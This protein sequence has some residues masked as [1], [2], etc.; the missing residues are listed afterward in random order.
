[1]SE[2][3]KQ[4]NPSSMVEIKYKKISFRDLEFDQGDTFFARGQFGDVKKAKWNGKVVAVKVFSAADRKCGFSPE[5]VSLSLLQ[6]HDH[7]VTLYG[8]CPTDSVTKRPFLVLEFAPLSLEKILHE[9]KKKY[10]YTADHVMSWSYQMALGLEF[11]HG[12]KMLHRDIKPSNI[13]LFHHGRVLK[14]CDFGT[15]KKLENTLSNTNAVGT[16]R[17]MAP[18]VIRGKYYTD[19]CD[20]FSYGIVLWEMLTRRRPVLANSEKSNN[21]MVIMFAMA[22]G[23]I[24]TKIPNLPKPMAQLIDKCFDGEPQNRPSVVEIRKKIGF[25]CKYMKTATPLIPRRQAKSESTHLTSLSDQSDQFVA[26]K[27]GT[28]QHTPRISADSAVEEEVPIEVESKQNVPAPVETTGYQPH[29][30]VSHGNTEQ[31]VEGRDRSKTVPERPTNIPP[32][33]TNILGPTGYTSPPSGT[34]TLGRYPGYT[35]QSSVPPTSSPSSQ[36]R[37]QPTPPGYNTIGHFRG[38][39]GRYGHQES[40]HEV[41]YVSEELLSDKGILDGQSE[42]Y[43]IIEEVMK[44]H[45]NFPV[46]SGSSQYVIAGLEPELQPIIPNENNP[47]SM[48]L[49]RQYSAISEQVMRIRKDYENLME[50][51]VK[52]NREMES[53]RKKVV[54]QAELHLEYEKQCKLKDQLIKEYDRLDR[55]YQGLMTKNSALPST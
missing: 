21:F 11:I 48:E 52:L 25:L 29:A 54:Q 43:Q 5:L 38:Q 15:A 28:Q 36:P 3:N 39:H 4:S 12:K 20:I 14:Y 23:A 46:A 24:P 16:I 13:L 31:D 40:E 42:R 18:E 37:P 55:E 41:E 27:Q 1:M 44:R 26:D 6:T 10:W 47:R 32:S 7:I 9:C 45:S 34:Q 53:D 8:A 2:S 30:D 49:Y 19:R 50:E 51:N 22:Q 35:S 17:Y 33:S